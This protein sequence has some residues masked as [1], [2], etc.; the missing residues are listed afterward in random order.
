MTAFRS[1]DTLVGLVAF[2]LVPWIGAVLYRG[3]RDARLPIGRGY[4]D[5]EE[6]PGTFRVLT[7]LYA[8]AAITAGVIA[9]DL[10]LGV[11]ER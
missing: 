9:A 3:L 6:R 7:A 1:E 5:R 4:V 2:A 11:T 8:I 10:L